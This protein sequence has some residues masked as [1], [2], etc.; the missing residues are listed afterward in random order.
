[1]LLLDEATSALDNKSEKL[2]QRA[3]DKTISEKKCTIVM[4]AHRLQ[5]VR[6][7]DVI[8]VMKDGVIVE[9]G[10]HEEL[11]KSQ[12]LYFEMLNSQVY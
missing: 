1:M 3:I 5:T 8:V 12:G 9:Q 2:V 4:V 6:N 7:A 10:N 11:I